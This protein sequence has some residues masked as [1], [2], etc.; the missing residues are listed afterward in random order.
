MQ[1]PAQMPTGNDFRSSILWY[2]CPT[3]NSSLKIFDDV[4]ACDLWFGPPFQPKTLATP[5][6]WRLPEKLFWWPFFWRTLAAM[7][8]V[9]SLEHSCPWPQEGLSSKRLPLAL[10]SDFFV[11]LALA[12]SLVSSTPPLE[13]TTHLKRTWSAAEPF[14]QILIKPT[15]NFCMIWQDLFRYSKM[16]ITSNVRITKEYH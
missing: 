3:K 4:V 10:A 13:F 12:L 5:T 8:L 2:L 7:F 11:S 14:C 16:K 15:V 6:N 9:L 1:N